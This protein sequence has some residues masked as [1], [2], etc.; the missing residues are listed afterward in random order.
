M[1]TAL[2]TI[3]SSISEAAGDMIGAAKFRAQRGN[4]NRT[5]GQAFTRR[6]FGLDT[7]KKVRNSFKGAFP[8]STAANDKIAEVLNAIQSDPDRGMALLQQAIDPKLGGAFSGSFTDPATGQK[9]TE[10]SPEKAHKFRQQAKDLIL[11]YEK[12]EMN[13]KSQ[14]IIDQTNQKIELIKAKNLE[15]QESITHQD[16]VNL[17]ER[18]KLVELQAMQMNAEKTAIQRRLDDPANAR[19]NTVRQELA[20]QQT[21]QLDLLRKQ[22]QIDEAQ[23]KAEQANLQAELATQISLIESNQDLIG[24][25]KELTDAVKALASRMAFASFGDEYDNMSPLARGAIEDSGGTRSS[26]IKSQSKKFGI[27]DESMSLR[28]GEF[29]PVVIPGDERLVKIQ[30]KINRA[31]EAYDDA[32][33]AGNEKLAKRYEIQLDNFNAE[34]EIATREAERST[35][36]TAGLQ[37]GFNDIYT[38]TDSIF[39]RL[40]VDLP[41][42]FR[43]GMV[44]ALEQSMDK[45]ETFGDAMRG[46]A[47]D[48]LKTIRRA[49]LQ[50]S[51]N[52]FT[53]LLG[54]G[55]SKDFR[56]SGLNPYQSGGAFVPGSGTGD[57][58]PAMLEPGEYVMNRK[59]VGAVGRGNLDKINFGMAPRFSNGGTMML[60]ES[61]NSPRMSGFF[62]ASD[63]PE[64]MEAR[65]KARADYDKKQA[66]K[67]EKKSLRNAF[68]ST[69]LSAG[70][71]KGLGA[72]AGKFGPKKAD[73]TGGMQPKNLALSRQVD[74]DRAI[75][76]AGGPEQFASQ[77][78][79]SSWTDMLQSGD[80]SGMDFGRRK[81]GYIGRGFTNRDSVP[82]YMAGGEFVMNNRAVRK[83]G[84]GFMGRLNGGVIPT[85]QAGGPVPGGAAAAP[86]NT[87]SAANTNN[88]SINVSVGGGGSGQGGSQSTGNANA[89]QQ[90]NE[91]QATQ[92]KELSERIR[93]AVIDVISQEQRLG[94]SLSK[95]A[96]QG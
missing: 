49:S 96:R 9:I 52:S 26:F 43:D 25:D 32:V 91:D 7:E 69:L 3:G 31:Q 6:Q 15:K 8:Q 34:G 33:A 38:Q 63:N 4:L 10:Q 58:V 73:M 20:R 86:L 12:Q 77:Q 29:K 68:L 18:N 56:E 13:L 14:V 5:I 22:M 24:A 84:L 47:I 55:A 88:I 67:A 95:T 81:G 44:N 59:A 48:F 61:V 87:Q 94:G 45:A 50:Y 17:I 36:F 54:L 16:K 46:V 39:Y 19:G 23:L 78:G 37:D 92:G 30:E 70:I 60:N 74:L 79:Y 57:R 65:E 35:Q 1:N 72:L 11:A 28:G 51:M 90:S 66:K 42:T 53:S 75:L 82:A 41:T 93:A 85:M 71:S 64:L 76:K 89:D 80:L 21:G 27:T 83:Y 2:T 40:G 62:L